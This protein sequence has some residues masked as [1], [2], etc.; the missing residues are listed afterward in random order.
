MTTSQSTMAPAP[1]IASPSAASVN[2]TH[3]EIDL[4]RELAVHRELGAAGGLAARKRRKVEIGG[5]DGLLELVDGVAG[6]E[7]PGH[8]GLADDDLAPSA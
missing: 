2:G 5:A 6:D 4:R 3:A 1:P 7:D 8:V